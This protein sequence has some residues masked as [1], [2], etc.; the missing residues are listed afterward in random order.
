MEAASRR[1]ELAVG[2][3][4]RKNANDAKLFHGVVLNPIK[5]DIVSFTDE[6]KIIVLAED[7]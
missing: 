2:Y 4:L 6:D 3:R 1:K 7:W 5:T